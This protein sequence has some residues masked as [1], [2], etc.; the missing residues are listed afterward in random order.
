MA[1]FSDEEIRRPATAC[2]CRAKLAHRVAKSIVAA[3]IL[4]TC[5]ARRP[6]ILHKTIHLTPLEIGRSWSYGEVLA[7][8]TETAA[9][10][11][12]EG[13][14]AQRSGIER[15]GDRTR[16]HFREPAA[17]VGLV[18]SVD[19]EPAEAGRSSAISG[20]SQ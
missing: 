8:L 16:G 4:V 2:D 18:A 7:V 10:L 3:S 15:S 11:E 14:L 12:L 13:V 5:G 19:V 1:G 6:R 20:L 9:S 17:H